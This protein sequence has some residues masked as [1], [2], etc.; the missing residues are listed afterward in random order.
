MK[1]ASAE[2][3]LRTVKREL[4]EKSSRNIELRNELE[5][6]RRIGAQMANFCFSLGQENSTEGKKLGTHVQSF[7]RG[8][9]QN[10]DAIKRV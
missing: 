2:T 9:H 3:K 4:K 5:A 1:L 10:W 7:M 6:R 8:M